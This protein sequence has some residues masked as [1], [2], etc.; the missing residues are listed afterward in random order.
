VIVDR[1]NAIHLT[2]YR[3]IDRRSSTCVARAT[4]EQ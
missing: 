2:E 3:W 4:G 1:E